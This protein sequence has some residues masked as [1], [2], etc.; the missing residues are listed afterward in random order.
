MG[1]QSFDLDTLIVDT[2]GSLVIVA[3]AKA[4]IIRFNPAAE[5]ILGYA[6]GEVLGK[7]ICDIFPLPE[8]RDRCR[9][10]FDK[11]IAGH[12]SEFRSIWLTK[13]GERRHISFICHGAIGPSGRIEFTVG[14]G[15]DITEQVL[16]EKALRESELRF[17]TM[18]DSAAIGIARVDE[19]GRY[20]HVNRAFCG[21]TGYTEEELLQRDLLSITHPDDRKENDRLARAVFSGELQ[22]Y[23]FEK[24]YITKRGEAV[25]VQV[26][27]SLADEGHGKSKSLIGLFENITERR[28]AEEMRKKAYADVQAM[29]DTLEKRVE[30]RTAELKSQGE[31][32]A[33]SER[34]L[35]SVLDSMGDGVYVTDETGR[36]TL[37]N[38]EAERLTGRAE[39]GAQTLAERANRQWFFRTDGTRILPEDLS[40]YRAARGESVDDAVTLLRRPGRPDLWISSTSRPL[41]DE[42]SALCGA[43]MVAR[44]VTERKRHE[45]DLRKAY[46][47]LEKVNASLR[48][49][50]RH[51]K[52]SAA[53]NLRLAR[54]VEH[55]VR[56]NLAGLLGLVAVMRDREFD[57]RS[58]ADAIEGRLTAMLHVHQ[59][60]AD[61]HWTP[62]EL[63]ELICGALS[64]L[65][66]LAPYQATAQ[67]EGDPIY[68]P[69]KQ[70]LPLT[71]IL[72][73]WFMNSC[74]YGAHSVAGGRVAIRWESID[75][76]DAPGIRLFWKETGGPAIEA[77]VKPSLGSELVQAFVRRELRGRCAL[78]YPCTGA[79]H[80]IEFALRSD[81][82]AP[83]SSA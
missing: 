19:N 64:A 63:Q 51:H 2:V 26:S 65:R 57:V 46:E 11:I 17:R 6:A 56:N 5:R 8:N 15:I 24:R 47:T 4:R 20:L 31:E 77:P 50:E 40:L 49:S 33:H 28:Q 38:P 36:V 81:E 73:E 22:S 42:N 44:D 82:S 30:E 37:M 75:A 72:V 69:P 59:L 68:I 35:R 1:D 45:D 61:A 80:L 70:V 32:L 14:T 25:W 43:V 74:K 79:D 78:R 83:V 41:R 34:V 7:A 76:K 27:T 53:S 10:R 21:I 29:N 39:P 3:N 71:L 13:A 48:K 9:A 52:E 55:R 62:V 60:L 12:D 18:I 67:T 58:F 23:V 16:A 54:E 66:H